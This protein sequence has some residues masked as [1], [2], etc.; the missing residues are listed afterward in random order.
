[1]IDSSGKKPALGGGR[2]SGCFWS[3][4]RELPAGD[5]TGLVIMLGEGVATVITAT[6]AK[7][8]SVGI[9]ALSSGNLKSVSEQVRNRY[10]KS[11]IYVIAD[12]GNGFDKAV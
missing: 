5:G 12:I 1:M 8:G 6:E 10:P 9:A 7:S 4:V 11:K 3:S 2:K